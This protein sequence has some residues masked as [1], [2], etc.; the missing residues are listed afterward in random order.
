[1]ERYSKKEKRS[2]KHDEREIKNNLFDKILRPIGADFSN[3]NPSR[4]S[5]LP[6]H[7]KDNGKLQELLYLNMDHRE[8]AIL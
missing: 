1:M 8:G 7:T 3:S 4:M 5:R 6:G 2:W